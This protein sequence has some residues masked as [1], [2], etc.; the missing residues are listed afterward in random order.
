MRVPLLN[1]GSSLQPVRS[2]PETSTRSAT[3][4]S[5]AQRSVNGNPPA[6][7]K[8]DTP[9]W[10][11]M[12]GCP[13]PPWGSSCLLRYC[14]YEGIELEEF[15]E[16]GPRVEDEEEG[17]PDGGARLLESLPRPLGLGGGSGAGA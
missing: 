1:V 7:E 9:A 5:P 17:A 4:R 15:D 2:T 16:R 10:S 6:H 12:P 14:K 11:I 8:E 13:E 3:D